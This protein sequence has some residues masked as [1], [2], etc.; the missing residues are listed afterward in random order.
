M[1]SLIYCCGNV[2]RHSH[3]TKT[4]LFLKVEHSGGKG[5]K[6]KSSSP[7]LFPK[8]VQGHSW[9]Y[10]TVSQNRK[11]KGRKNK[12]KNEYT[13]ATQPSKRSLEHLSQKIKICFYINHLHVFIT[14]LFIKH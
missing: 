7:P 6:V 3:I 10:E 4:S 13:A 12:E 8:E 11:G 2:K 1:I 5:R 14:S 9:L